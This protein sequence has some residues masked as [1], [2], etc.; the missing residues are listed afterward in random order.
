MKGGTSNLNNP[1]K[2]R[3]IRHIVAGKE[4]SSGK[5]AQNTNMSQ[6]QNKGLH[7]EDYDPL[8]EDPPRFLLNRKDGSLDNEEFDEAPLRYSSFRVDVNIRNP[9]FEVGMKFTACICD[10]DPHEHAHAYFN[11][12]LFQQLYE[13]VLKP[14]NGKDLWPQ[15]DQVQLDPLI[16]CV[17]PGRPKKVRRKDPFEINKPRRN[18]RSINPM[19][20]LR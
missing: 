1:K 14:I 3:R 5:R 18:Q 17:Q 12:E 4:P 9:R 13:H 2:N 11:K 8:I 10:G 20:R 6:N 16:S 15:V 19:Q 7:G